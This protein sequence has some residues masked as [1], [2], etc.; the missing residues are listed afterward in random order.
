M[1]TIRLGQIEMRSNGSVGV[2]LM[3]QVEE[4]GEVL[5]SEPHRTE[6]LQGGDVDA[7]MDVV[8]QHLEAMGYPAVPAGDIAYIKALINVSRG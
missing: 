5:F 4:D 6:I 2:K 8:N 7:Q 3:K 1:R